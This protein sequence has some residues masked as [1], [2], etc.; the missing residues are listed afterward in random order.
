MPIESGNENDNPLFLPPFALILK[1]HP[2]FT[3]IEFVD[4]A[5]T[6]TDPSHYEPP[7]LKASRD[8]TV[9]EELFIP[10]EKMHPQSFTSLFSTVPQLDD[11]LQADEI[12]QDERIQ[13]KATSRN[14]PRK[15][16][17]E[18]GLA[19]RMTQRAVT[20]YNPV[21]AS[22]LPNV[23]GGLLDYIPFGSTSIVNSVKN[24]THQNL[25]YFSP[26][27][28]DIEWNSKIGMVVAKRSVK[29]GKP[30]ASVPLYAIMVQQQQQQQQTQES[31]S[32]IGEEQEE[33]DATYIYHEGCFGQVG[34]SLQLCPLSH[35]PIRVISSN[36]EAVD[37]DHDHEKPNA[38]YQWSAWND[39]NQK[40][41]T[42][43][44]LEITKVRLI[45]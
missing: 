5:Y 38:E 2:W 16:H 24:Y 22:L 31:C 9:G 3:N 13:L 14:L 4:L 29:Q 8:I 39:E 40:R 43:T 33:C 18:V 12:I 1:H 7:V 32:A 36:T 42:L 6:G 37:N 45:E 10:Y 44:P 41:S 17:P 25:A 30:I 11:Y 21:V 15:R 26:C 28:D 20:R 23:A 27:L 34:S 19:L 35:G